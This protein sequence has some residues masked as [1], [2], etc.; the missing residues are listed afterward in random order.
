MAAHPIREMVRQVTKI[1]YKNDFMIMSLFPNILRTSLAPR[2]A[3]F[4]LF[5][6]KINHRYDQIKGPA[7]AVPL[8]DF[9][10]R[11]RDWW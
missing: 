3:V 8:D 7:L 11:T 6:N 2:F 9:S 5:V 4:R 10:G 1:I